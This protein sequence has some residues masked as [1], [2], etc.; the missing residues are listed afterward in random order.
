MGMVFPKKPKIG[1]R[2][3]IIGSYEIPRVFYRTVRGLSAA[4]RIGSLG[5]LIWYAMLKGT[6]GRKRR[7]AMDV[8]ALVE[9]WHKMIVGLA[10]AHDKNEADR[11]EAAV[12]ECLTP[13]LAAPIKQVREF[14]PRLLKSLKDDPKVPYLVWR[15]YEV[16][17][18]MVVSKAPDEDIKQL[19]T[20]LAKEITAM[21]EQDVKDQIP[22]ALVRALQWRSPEQLAKVKSALV[23]TQARGEK[24]R[25]RGRESCLFLEVG[26]TEDDPKACV[27]I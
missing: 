18:D 15:S 22:E 14:Y 9:K 1:I 5:G 8:N 11:Y 17:V 20:D 26:G 3:Q 6:T 13:I 12:E 4:Q 7:T 24:S 16:W 25:L 19:K 21:V 2:T 23:E 10:V 27:Q